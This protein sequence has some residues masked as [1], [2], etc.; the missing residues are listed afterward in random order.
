M[1]LVSNETG[2]GTG[3]EDFY[4]YSVTYTVKTRRYSMDTNGYEY[5]THREF[6]IS[7]PISNVNDDPSNIYLCFKRETLSNPGGLPGYP[8]Y[9]YPSG[10]YKKS[11]R[12][13]RRSK[14]SRRSRSKR[15][16]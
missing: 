10:G 14:R 4:E 2:R 7:F 5:E 12:K 15:R 16:R 1:D 6:E 8:F 13:F 3:E 9:N 11:Q